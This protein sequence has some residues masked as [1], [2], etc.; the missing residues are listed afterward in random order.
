MFAFGAPFLGSTGNIHLNAPVV[1]MAAT[2]N[3]LGYRFVASDGGVFASGPPRSWD[4]WA[5]SPSTNPSLPRPL[6]GER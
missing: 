2:A 1:G 6:L 5:V 3:G 4:R